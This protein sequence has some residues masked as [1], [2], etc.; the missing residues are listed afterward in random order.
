MDK[1]A[2]QPEGKRRRKW[3]ADELAELGDLL[4]R[5]ISIQEIARLLG[6]DL[7]DVE[8]KVVE[9]GERAIESF[10]RAERDAHT[11]RRR[12]GKRRF[13]GWEIRRK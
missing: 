4:L 3:S 8:N 12:A 9:K 1:G 11:D 5:E 13:P 6:R 7:D 2:D 10:D